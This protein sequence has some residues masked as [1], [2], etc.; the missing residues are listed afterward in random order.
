[1]DAEHDASAGAHR[2]GVGSPGGQIPPDR[3]L[4]R[5]P[6]CAGGQAVFTTDDFDLLLP[7]D[8]DNLVHARAACEAPGYE[9][10]LAED[11]LDRPRDRWLAERVV[12]RLSLRRVT[13]PDGLLVDL[14]FVMKGYAFETVWN[15]RRLFLI[16]GI[17]I[18]LQPV[19][20]GPSPIP[21]P[22]HE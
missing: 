2:R 20:N 7:P 21:A 1:M 3:C 8:P 15:D 11:P 10:W 9:L 5:Q 14:T 13:G 16:E 6:L 17:E 4:R 18:P 12:E 22:E 19:R